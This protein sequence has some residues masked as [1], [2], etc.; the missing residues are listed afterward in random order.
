MKGKQFDKATHAS[1]EIAMLISL[2]VSI[3][4]MRKVEIKAAPDLR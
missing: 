2:A 4:G 1:C 3:G